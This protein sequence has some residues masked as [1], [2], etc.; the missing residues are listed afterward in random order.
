MNT[1][2][3]LNY[4]LDAI[5]AAL[6]VF[7]T[8]VGI[9]TAFRLMEE[10]QPTLTLATSDASS[11]QPGGEGAKAF[12]A[13]KPRG[14]TP[15]PLPAPSGHVPLPMPAQSGTAS[16]LSAPMPPGLSVDR[17]RRLGDERLRLTLRNT[18]GTLT[19][20]DLDFGEFN[21][22]EV[23]YTPPVYR[24]K[25]SFAQGSALNFTLHSEQ[26]ERATYHFFVIF[27]DEAGQRY[28]QEVAGMGVEPPI[29]EQ[30]HTVGRRVQR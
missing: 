22:M 27:E 12:S 17:V 19:F 29:I 3:L 1:L 21:E 6:G 15:R 23:D 24:D 28:R 25:E 10:E 7:A 13:A 8:L 11:A 18:G 4:W 16:R 5:A 14:T 20:C 9:Y 26:L 2:F 30:A